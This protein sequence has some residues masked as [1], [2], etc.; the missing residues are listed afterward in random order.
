VIDSAR[1][2]PDGLRSQRHPEIAEGRTRRD[3]LDLGLYLA[4]QI[5]LPCVSTRRGA[6][7]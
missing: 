5:A 6:A 4:R 3:G 1:P 2:R 7:D